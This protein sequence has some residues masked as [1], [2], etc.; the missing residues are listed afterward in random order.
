MRPLAACLGSRHAEAFGILCYHRVTPRS[1]AAA[2]PT[3][4]VTPAQFRRQMQGLLA[5]NFQPWPLRAVLESRR[6]GVPIP[7]RVFVVTFDDGYECVYRHAWPVLRELRIPA[8]LFLTTAYLDRHGPFPFDREMIESSTRVA[9]ETWRPLATEQ[10]REMLARGGIEIGCHTHTHADFRGRPRAL[11]HDVLESLHVLRARFGIAEATFAFPYG[12]KRF[13][14]SGPRLAAAV[15]DAGVLCALTTES[16]LVQRGSDPFDW[17]RFTVEG[18][19]SA[20][21]IATLLSGWYSLVR[22]AWRQWYPLPV[23]EDAT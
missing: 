9:P 17:G 10:C 21:S 4:N 20:T 5:R 3:M 12:Q 15:R 1:P 11:F 16:D 23:L 7:P 19:D 6:R 22:D 13:G 2:E 8:T 18:S 14:F